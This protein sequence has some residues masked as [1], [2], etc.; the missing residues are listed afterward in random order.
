MRHRDLYRDE[1]DDELRLR[2]RFPLFF[3]LWFAFVAILALS[4]IG[5][6]IWGGFQVVNDPAAI[7]RV[8]GQIVSGFQEQ[9]K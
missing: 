5:L 3:K 2:P 9:V 4:I 7:G 1:W 6:T 8:A